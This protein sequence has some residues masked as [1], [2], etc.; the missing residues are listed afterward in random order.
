MRISQAMWGTTISGT[1]GTVASQRAK[2]A[3]ERKPSGPLSLELVAA[4]KFDAEFMSLCN[5]IY[6]YKTYQVSKFQVKAIRSGLCY[7]NVKPKQPEGELAAECVAPK[8]RSHRAK[9]SEE[10]VAAIKFDLKTM[11]RSK[12]AEKY[13]D[14]GIVYYHVNSIFKGAAYSYVEPKERK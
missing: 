14:E 9:L 7:Q 4:I 2:A 8:K 12:V 1:L 10:L 13:A 5:L 6:K 11:Q 3:K